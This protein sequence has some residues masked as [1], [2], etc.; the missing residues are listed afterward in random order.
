M[1]DKTRCAADQFISCATFEEQRDIRSI[2][3]RI[4]NMVKVKVKI[5]VGVGAK[6]WVRVRFRVR[7]RSYAARLVKAQIDQMRLTYLPS[8]VHWSKTVTKVIPTELLLVWCIR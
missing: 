4:Y 8:Y 1:F 5:R 6:V 2:A 3:Q 7:V